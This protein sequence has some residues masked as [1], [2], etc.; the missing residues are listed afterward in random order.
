MQT[1]FT[2]S[3]DCK[4]TPFVVTPL[5]AGATIVNQQGKV[6]QVLYAKN[7]SG[8]IIDVFSISASDPGATWLVSQRLN[9]VLGS[10]SPTS[11]PAMQSSDSSKNEQLAIILGSV[12]SFAFLL[13]IGLSVWF[14]YRRKRKSENEMREREN[15]INPIVVGSTCKV[16]KMHR[17]NLNDELDVALGDQV[18]IH[19]VYDDSWIAASV[20]GSAGK[21]GMIPITCVQ[22]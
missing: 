18:I 15:N 11:T 10:S 2:Y 4:E 13:I 16:V 5:N 3:D 14:Y 22:T 8:A 20:V 19:A 7:S 17:G 12:L 6:G 1:I 21:T 9:G